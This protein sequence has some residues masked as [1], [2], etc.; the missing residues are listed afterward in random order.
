MA[1]C[2]KVLTVHSHNNKTECEQKDPLLTIQLSLKNTTTATVMGRRWS[3]V[4]HW[5]TCVSILVKGL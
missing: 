4:S 5:H 2:Q 3:S 1:V